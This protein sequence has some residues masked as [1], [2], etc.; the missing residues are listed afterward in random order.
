MTLQT[1][2]ITGTKR[3]DFPCP[4]CKGQGSF[5]EDQI[6]W[7]EIRNPCSACGGEGFIEVGSKLH[8]DLA[9]GSVMDRIGE[10]SESWPEVVSE[11]EDED[12]FVRIYAELD[13]IF[14]PKKP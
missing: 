11:T 5:F 1:T 6:D 14:V 3:K 9:K 8:A 12:P 13:R 2:P 10:M 7:Y 4:W